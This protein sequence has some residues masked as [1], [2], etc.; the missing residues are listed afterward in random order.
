M[1]KKRNFAAEFREGI[2]ALGIANKT[3]KN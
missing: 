1:K 2:I 3:K